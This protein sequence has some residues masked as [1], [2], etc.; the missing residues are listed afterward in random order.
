MRKE[1][2]LPANCK[3]AFVAYS[4]ASEYQGK[5]VWCDEEDDYVTEED[6]VDINNDGIIMFQMEA[7]TNVNLKYYD[8]SFVDFYWRNCMDCSYR[9]YDD[10]IGGIN[11]YRNDN[12]KRKSAIK[13]SEFIG[14]VERDIPEH[15]MIFDGNTYYF[16][17]EHED[18]AVAL[19]LSNVERSV[20]SWCTGTVEIDELNINKTYNNFWDCIRNGDY[21]PS[22]Y[23]NGEVVHPTVEQ[24][25]RE[26][27]PNK[28]V[29]ADDD[30]DEDED[31]ISYY[32]DISYEWL[33]ERPERHYLDFTNRSYYLTDNEPDSDSY[34]IELTE[35]NYLEIL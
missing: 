11:V 31:Y 26:W 12:C 15:L 30:E 20:G 24:L 9:L 5:T 19:S 29:F 22:L 2:I 7:L 28:L 10:C 14:F 4:F 32:I 33:D 6:Y 23:I 35:G 25:L 27:S 34:F 21:R 16:L 17:T 18:K 3:N 13:Q 1:L 8:K